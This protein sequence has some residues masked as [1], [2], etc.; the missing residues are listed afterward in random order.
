MLVTRSETNDYYASQSPELLAGFDRDARNCRPILAERYD[1]YPAKAMLLAA[2][3]RFGDLIPELPNIGGDN[4][5]LTASLFSSARCLALYQAM[6]ARNLSAADTG[7]VLYDAVLARAAEPRPSPTAEWLSR[8]ELMDRRRQR[9]RRSQQRRY[10]WDYVHKFVAGDGQTFDFGYNFLECATDK[11]FRARGAAEFTPCY[12]FLDYPKAQ[13]DGLSPSRTMTLA[14][15]HRMCDHRFREGGPLTQ[16][17]S[18][19]FLD[20]ACSGWT[21][22]QS[23]DL[24]RVPG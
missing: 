11:F 8:E 4:K 2:R 6:K 18:P 24:D 19:P 16:T 21:V 15:G 20:R 23:E 3:S 12:C 5:H 1:P 7:K 13:L 10:V 14:E 22:L 9:A 17:W